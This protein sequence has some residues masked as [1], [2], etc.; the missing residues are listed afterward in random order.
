MIQVIFAA[1]ASP[2]PSTQNYLKSQQIYRY[3]KKICNNDRT[4]AWKSKV[5]S[6]GNIEP[7]ATYDII[8]APSLYYSSHRLTVKFDGKCSKQDKVT[9]PHRKVVNIYTIYEINR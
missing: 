4:S 1:K 5:L 3:L 8:L 2:S 6:D 9:F 7:P